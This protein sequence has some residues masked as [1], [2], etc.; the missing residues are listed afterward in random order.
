LKTG[1]KT[2]KDFDDFDIED[3][4]QRMRYWNSLKE[5]QIKQ[6]LKPLEKPKDVVYKKY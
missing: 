4:L 1:V 5:K 3:E 6:L 2:A